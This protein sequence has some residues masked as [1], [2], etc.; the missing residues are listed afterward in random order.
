MQRC[1][2]M[3]SLAISMYRDHP[4]I[5]RVSVAGTHVPVSR[6]KIRAPWHYLLRLV[7]GDQLRPPLNTEPCEPM[8]GPA[9]SWLVGLCA[10]LYTH[11]EIQYSIQYIH[12]WILC[13]NNVCLA[14]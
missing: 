8:A 10:G 3:R 6:A 2:A 5:M 14:Q 11:T 4:L 1:A 13:I 9:A 7:I 12:T